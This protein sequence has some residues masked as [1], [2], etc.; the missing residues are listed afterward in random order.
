MNYQIG[1]NRD[2]GPVSHRCP[3]F[4][5]LV[6]NR[7]L[8]G[9]GGRPG[10]PGIVGTGSCIQGRMDYLRPVPG[11]RYRADLLSGRTGGANYLR[12]GP[13]PDHRG[14]ILVVITPAP[15]N[16]GILNTGAASVVIE[17]YPEI[18][19]WIL[20][21]HSL[22]G[23]SAGIYFNNHPRA[24]DAMALWD[25]CP[26]DSADLS[27]ND[28]AVIS[29]YETTEGY[30]NTDNFDAQRVLLPSGTEFTAIESASHAQF[31]NYG[32]QK[33]DVVPSLGLTDQHDRVV[34]IML[35]F[36]HQIQ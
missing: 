27:D 5:R 9:Q 22:G 14:V 2:R 13:A 20:A 25:S 7:H 23:A 19:T 34:E 28:L 11:D 15:L 12:P 24:I 36:I 21:R 18:T 32:P 3:G 8:P 29:V 30:P 33:G 31:G 4:V 6:Q 1:I 10:C 35:E 17:Q 16:L 26:P